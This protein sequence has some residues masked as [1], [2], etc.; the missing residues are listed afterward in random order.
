MYEQRKPFI[1]LPDCLSDALHTERPEY[2]LKI[3]TPD[4]MED[5]LSPREGVRGSVLLTSLSGDSIAQ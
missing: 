1:V 4:P 3:Q 2:S 5:T